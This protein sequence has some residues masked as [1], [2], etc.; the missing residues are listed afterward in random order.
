MPE[1]PE[2]TALT[3]LQIVVMLEFLDVLSTDFSKKNP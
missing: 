1:W 2:W 3:G